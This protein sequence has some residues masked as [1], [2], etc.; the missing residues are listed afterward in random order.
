MSDVS[1]VCELAQKAFL[2]LAPLNHEIRNESLNLIS[3]IL[4][5]HVNQILEEN[6]KDV[7]VAKLMVKNDEIAGPLLDRL[8]LDELKIKEISDG[9][10]AVSELQDPLNQIQMSTLLDKG[11]QLDRM[12]CPIG[13]IAAIFESRPDALVQIASLCIKSGNVVIL[14]GGREA[15]HT[16][17]LL[18]DLLSSAL[19]DAGLPENTLQLLEGR[20][21]VKSL[22]SRDDTIDLLIPRGGN[23][24]V[25]YIKENSNIPVLGHTDG[26]CHLYIDAF[27]DQEMAIN[28][29]VDSKT[30]YPGV[31]NAIET[32]LVHQ[33]VAE[34][35]LPS[36]F[37][38]L[39]DKNV[40]I[41]GCRKT[42]S[43]FP[44]IK[45]ATENDW[46]TEYLDLIISVRIVETMEEAISHINRYGSRHTDSIVTNNQNSSEKFASNVDSASIML[47][48]ST[49]FADGYRYG[50]GA[51][52]GI[53]TD[54]IH[55]RGPMGIEG[56]I[57]YKYKLIGNGQCVSEYSGKNARK[58]LHKKIL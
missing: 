33:D 49:R 6:Q 12:T 11:L 3:E 28:L 40:E 46:K 31:C 27:A 48:A 42:C 14:K 53:A 36:I 43:I 23:D 7:E 57:T 37:K 24:F 45:E 38:A 29:T 47:N 4:E 15:F 22:L 13:V 20:E 56:L 10:L 51:E 54:K 8:K 30:Q 18:T 26:I 2:E 19:I 44:K 55:A 32:L 16:N 21:D 9:V 50:F 34:K 58:F 1:L 25:R 35:F 39:I 41:R 17:L 5:S 52:V